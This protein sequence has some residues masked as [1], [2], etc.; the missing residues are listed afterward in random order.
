MF[1]SKNPWLSQESDQI[2]YAIACLIKTKAA[3][4]D[5]AS[6]LPIRQ[7]EVTAFLENIDTVTSAY[8]SDISNYRSSRELTAVH[9]PSLCQVLLSIKT[10]GQPVESSEL[11]AAIDQ[12]FQMV[13][14]VSGSIRDQERQHLIDT[15][16]PADPLSEEADINYEVSS[17]MT[18]AASYGMKTGP[19]NI[20]STASNGYS[21]LTQEAS[22]RASGAG[23]Y[24]SSM[25]AD[26]LETATATVTDPI[27]SHAAALGVSLSTAVG[28]M[29]WSAVAIS[30]LCPPALPVSIGIGILE[31]TSEYGNAL[32]AASE[33]ASKER[34]KNKSDRRRDQQA[35]LSKLQGKS[36]IVSVSSPHVFVTMNTDD[37]TAEGTIL[38][39]A[40]VG[41]VLSHIEQDDLSLL[42]RYAPDEDTKQILTAWMLRRT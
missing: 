32:R 31:G 5:T 2:N 6:L 39:G 15:L 34:E 16:P 1:G 21:K 20:I 4:Q 11:S 30:I 18:K 26:I 38:S 13:E 10:A 7:T 23:A 25:V 41:K 12:V 17:W 19:M 40:F 29:T 28:S 35:A 27:K 33:T 37:N 22:R 8:R 36:P 3:V 14:K 42:V 24:A 9:L